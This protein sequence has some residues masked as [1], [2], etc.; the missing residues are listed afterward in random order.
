MSD[1]IYSVWVG[2]GEI[3]NNY[4]SEEEALTLR[5]EYEDAGYDDVHMVVSAFE[6][7]SINPVDSRALTQVCEHHRQELL[8]SDSKL[9]IN[10]GSGICDVTGCDKRADHC[11]TIHT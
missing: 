10:A 1:N 2:A 5:F 11:Y 4:I 3:N 7:I 6:G 8:L 9:D